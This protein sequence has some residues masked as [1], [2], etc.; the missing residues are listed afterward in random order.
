MIRKG[1]YLKVSKAAGIDARDYDPALKCY[2]TPTKQ[3][4]AAECDINNIL[5]KFSPEALEERL[6]AAEGVYRDFSE[7]L[8]YEE[9]RQLVSDCDDAFMSLPAKVRERFMNNPQLLID[10]LDDASNDEEA[11]KLG[12]KVRPEISDSSAAK[13]SAESVKNEG[14]PSST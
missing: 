10:F 7:D 5:E 8:T 11:I 12:L 2:V 6:M 1:D 9:A 3:E 13:N 4:F 14:A